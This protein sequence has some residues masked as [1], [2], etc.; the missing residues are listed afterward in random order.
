M[1]HKNRE[2]S[3]LQCTFFHFRNHMRKFYHKIFFMILILRAVD[4]FCFRRD[5]LLLLIITP[6]KTEVNQIFF[7]FKE[8]F[9]NSH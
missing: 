5:V 9:F 3:D 6:G 7:D 1:K 4:I 2:E 8:I